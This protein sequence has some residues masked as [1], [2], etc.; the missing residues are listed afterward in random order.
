MVTTGRSQQ[1]SPLECEQLRARL[2]AQRRTRLGRNGSLGPVVKALHDLADTL[3]V[4]RW[5]QRHLG[6]HTTDY[7]LIMRVCYGPLFIQDPRTGQWGLAPR[8]Q[9]PDGALDAAR[10][11]A[12]QVVAELGGERGATA[13]DARAAADRLAEILLQDQL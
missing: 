4:E 3:D 6:L 8:Q 2:R 11:L 10:T 13:G 9:R 1:V 12:K 5:K 7:T